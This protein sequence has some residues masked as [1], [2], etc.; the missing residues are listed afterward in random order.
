MHKLEQIRNQLQISKTEMAKRL[1][2]SKSNYSMII[3]GQ[4]GLSK[5]VALK[6]YQEF[7]IP[8]EDLLCAKVQR[9]E[10]QPT[11]TDGA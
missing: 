2:I 4:H 8:L 7:N 5:R 9:G 10:T 1:G 6:V 11:G 3:H